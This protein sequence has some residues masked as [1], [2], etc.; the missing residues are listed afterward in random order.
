MSLHISAI[1]IAGDA[2]DTI[3]NLFEKCEYKCPTPPETVRGWDALHATLVRPEDKAVVHH[4]SQTVIID[5]ELVMMLDEG[6]M[7]ELSKQ[8]GT[9]ITMVCES[10]SATYGFS[11]YRRGEK[12]RSLTA[13]DGETVD[14]FGDALPEEEAISAD[15]LSEDTILALLSKLGFDYFGLEKANE[16][17]VYHLEFAGDEAGEPQEPPQP[18][19]TTRVQKPWWKFW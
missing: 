14:E 8:Y 13:M 18:A 11:V 3:F 5:P 6:P 16:F 10:V 15:F 1:S 17:K 12:I 19:A 2:R 9:V 4:N 7:K